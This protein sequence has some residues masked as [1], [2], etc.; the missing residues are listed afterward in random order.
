MSENVV[1]RFTQIAGVLLVFAV[2]GALVFGDFLGAAPGDYHVRKGSQRLSEGK[3]AEAMAAFE[4][5]LEESPNHRGAL[6][7][8]ALVFIQREQYIKAEDALT[9]LIDYLDANLPEKRS[10]D[11]TGYGVLA[12]AHANLGILHDRQGRYEQAL[13]S[14]IAA[15][16]VDEESVDGPSIVHEV[17]YGYRASSVRDRAEYI[18]RELQKPPEE[19]LMRLPAKDAEQRMYKP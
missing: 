2:L 10:E 12:A 18:A 16:R 19:R 3:T 7:G 11:P 1:R 8:R 9:E 4:Q 17:L 6:M 14:Y 5:A 15:L 13:D